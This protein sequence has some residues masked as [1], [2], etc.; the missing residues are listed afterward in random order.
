[1]AQATSFL[2]SCVEAGCGFLRDKYTASLV[3]A[4]MTMPVWHAVLKSASENAAVLTPIAFFF[5]AILKVWNEWPAAEKRASLVARL[6]PSAGRLKSWLF[7]AAAILTIGLVFLFV[8]KGSAKAAP[9]PVPAASTP[10][11]KRKRSEDDTG[12]DTTDDVPDANEPGAPKWFWKAKELIGIAEALPNGRPNP[13]VREMFV[14]VD[15]KRGEAW[16]LA[17]DGLPAV[18]CR[19]VPWCSVFTNYVFRLCGING[20]RD[21]MA[22]SFSRSRNFTK[23]EQP[24]IGC[25][26]VMWRGQY[27]DGETGHVGFYAGEKGDRKI[28]V[29]GGNQHDQV[30][31]EEQ[32]KKKVIGYYWPRGKWESKTNRGAAVAAGGGA[33]GTTAVVASE[34]TDSATPVAQS[35]PDRVSSTVD[36]VKDTL[37]RVQEPLANSGHPKAMKLAMI[38]GI[39][40]LVLGIAGAAYAM[41][42]RSQDHNEGS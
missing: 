6:T 18:D 40:L 4:G 37:E 13:K 11:G 29:L 7:A 9:A 27:D 22:R 14:A 19:N 33:A 36:A 10:A 26:V 31:F 1:M 30:E 2:Y 39:V 42:H 3:F 32:W 23:L 5:V 24:R 12:G 21:A 25:V 41:Y 20:T 15:I 16:P 38:L 28:V 17:K 35:G 34:L 8:S